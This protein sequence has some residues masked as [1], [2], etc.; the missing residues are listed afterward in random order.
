MTTSISQNRLDSE[1]CAFKLCGNDTDN[2]LP[3]MLLT[4]Q[5]RIRINRF[6]K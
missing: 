1:F 4:L 2:Y 6:F 5:V 3:Y